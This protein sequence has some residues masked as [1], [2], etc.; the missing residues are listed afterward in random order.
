[1]SFRFRV[2]QEQWT[3]GAARKDGDVDLREIREV[4]LF[5]LGPVVFPAYASTTVGV[6]S[7]LAGLDDDD[8]ARLIADLARDVAPLLSEAGST[9]SETPAAAPAS[10]EGV[11]TGERAAFLRSLKL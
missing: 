9:T 3:Q 6:R 5:E 7:L 11:T 4:D 10:T 1:M 8:R 2:L